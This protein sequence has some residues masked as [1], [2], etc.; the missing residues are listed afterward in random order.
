MAA[1]SAGRHT[2]DFMDMD[3]YTKLK[4]NPKSPNDVDN[5]IGV[6]LK[7]HA[8]EVIV[9]PLKSKHFGGGRVFP[10]AFQNKEGRPR[11]IRVAPVRLT[12][13]PLARSHAQ[14]TE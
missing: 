8:G 5:L 3:L 14:S 2:N 6:V 12:L 9:E 4:M 10:Q 11:G 7:N 13:H 1:K